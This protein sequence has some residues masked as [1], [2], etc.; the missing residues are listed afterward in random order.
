MKTRVASFFLHG[1]YPTQV[2]L[3]A[4]SE[5]RTDVAAA[6]RLLG[7]STGDVLRAISLIEAA[8]QEHNAGSTLERSGRP[9]PLTLHAGT[10]LASGERWIFSQ[11][12]RDE[13]ASSA[14]AYKAERW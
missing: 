7:G 13:T 6:L 1:A 5:Q 8:A 9:D 11:W 4:P 10:P 12:F 3:D 2:R 14:S